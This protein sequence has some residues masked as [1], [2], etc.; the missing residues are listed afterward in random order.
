MSVTAI[1]PATGPLPPEPG[2]TPAE[3]IARARALLPLL[4]EQRAAVEQRTYYSA[5]V[6]SA[7]QDAGFYRL[8]VP[9]RYG[10]YE[11]GLETFMQVV[12][13]LARACPSTAWM[14]C[15]GA[16]HAVPAATLFDERA[17]DELFADGDFIAPATVIPSGTARRVDGGWLLDGTWAYCS[18]APYATHFM[19]HVVVAPDG[20]EPRPIMFVI[21]RAQWRRLDDWG[22]QMGLRGSGSHSIKVEDKFVPDHYFLD[23]HM[24][25]YTVSAD[26][27]GVR[28]HANPLYG[29]GP[30]SFMQFEAAALAVGMATGALD[31]YADLMR[32]RMTSFPPIALR[33][34][35]PDFQIWYGEAAGRIAAAEGAL[36]SGMRQWTTLAETGPESF[37]REE[38]WRI[39]TICRET[40]RLSWE[41][42]HRF[43]FPTAGSSAVR[44]G[45]H[46]ERVWRDMSMMQSHAGISIVLTTMANRELAKAHFGIA[47][48]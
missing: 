8:L 3:V 33:A 4:V 19:G 26:T 30:M 43:L 37:T 13:T 11:I 36:L 38:E 45:H 39:A 22:D 41:A 6:H 35:D 18:G 42:V 25:M 10:G 27:P 1:V 31:S 24:S 15:L 40:V 17:Q 2:L 14:F 28:L 48:H 9:A 47:D 7:F 21:P 5:E 34:E 16:V 29:G 12:S 32:T 20:G 23:T 46:I 44:A